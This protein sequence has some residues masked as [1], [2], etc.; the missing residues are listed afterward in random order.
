MIPEKHLILLTE[1]ANVTDS[2]DPKKLEISSRDGNT[3]PPYLLAEKSVCRSRSIIRTV[4]GKFTGSNLGKE[5]VNA[6]YG[7]PV[8]LTYRQSA[9]SLQSCL[10][11]CDPINGNPPGSTIPGILQARTL[12]DPMDC[13]LPG[14]SI[15]G[16]FQAG[17]LE[18][19]AIALSV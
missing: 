9:K 18:W 8:Y 19:G 6:I 17:V 12:D 14:S 16:I 2:V 1:D 10:T 13:S 15:H 11:L 4:H 5:Y 3:R 7:H